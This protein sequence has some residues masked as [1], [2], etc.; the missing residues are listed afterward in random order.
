[1]QDRERD[2]SD[3]RTAN[4]WREFYT[5]CV[6]SCVRCAS[7]G[8]SNSLFAEYKYRNLG[9]KGTTINRTNSAGRGGNT[10]ITLLLLPSQDIMQS[11]LLNMLSQCRAEGQEGGEL[12]KDSTE[13]LMYVGKNIVHFMVQY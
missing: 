6:A 5:Y 12:T 13:T 3:C 7:P 1:M 2:K 10:R 8:V 11:L 9:N 4:P